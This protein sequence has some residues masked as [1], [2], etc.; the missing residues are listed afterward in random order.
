MKNVIL[1]IVAQEHRN[2]FMDLLLLADESEEVVNEYINEGEMYSILYG[3]EIAGVALFTFHPEQIVEL[4]NVAL[5][6]NFRGRGLGK[7]ILNQAFEVYRT[8]GLEKMI[9]G[10]AN[11][12]IANLAFYQKAGF[13]MTEIKRGF[14]EKYPAPI[15]ENG[16][17]ALDMVMFEKVLAN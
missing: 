16:I 17:R 14:F 7:M 6:E 2:S 5:G 13:R 4:K 8:K 1:E 10:T 9:V 12:S 15:Y 3:G 11:S